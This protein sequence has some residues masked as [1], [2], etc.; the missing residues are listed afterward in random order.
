MSE[1]RD[2][3]QTPQTRSVCTS[4]RLLQVRSGPLTSRCDSWIRQ[5]P[6]YACKAERA[7]LRK[8]WWHKHGRRQH[9][10]REPLAVAA[11][12]EGARLARDTGQVHWA[13]SAQLAMATIEAER[14]EFDRAEELVREAEAQLLQIGATP[15]LALAQF[16]RGRGKVAHQYFEEGLEHLRRIVDPRGP[17]LQPI[18]RSLGPVGSR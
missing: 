9:L 7:L 11:A 3:C 18:H 13:A 4:W 16:V 14:G 5:W 6:A 17:G 8:H 1:F 10:A 2:Y 15:M 12:D